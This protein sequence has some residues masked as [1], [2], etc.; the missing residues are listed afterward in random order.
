MMTR[1]EKDAVVSSIKEKIEK[2]QAVFLTNL[3]GIPSV[4]SVRI[5]KNVREAKGHMVVT[6]NTLFARAAKGTFAEGLLSDLK[7]TSC[8]AFAYEDAAAVAKIVNDAS[9]EFENIVTIRGGQLGEQ[10]LSKADVVALAKLPSRPQMLG[11]L[12][13]TF[14]APVS[15]FARVLFA[16]QEQKEKQNA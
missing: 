10:K 16:I 12:L 13:A 1:A 2:S 8:V 3:V 7:G 6:R 14:N 11:T 15:A 4:D 9:G 5:R